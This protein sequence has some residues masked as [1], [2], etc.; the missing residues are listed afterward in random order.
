MTADLCNFCIKKNTIFPSVEALELRLNIP[1][2]YFI[3]YDYFFKSSAGDARWKKACLDQPEMRRE[4]RLASRQ[5]EAF[6]MLVLKNNYFAW[7]LSA[8]E[9]MP[10]L[11]TDYDSE[12]AR[13]DRKSCVEAYLG[14]IEID[15]EAP[16]NDDNECVSYLVSEKEEPAR[17]T[18]IKKRTDTEL[19]KVAREAKSNALYKKLKAELS[20]NPERSP[21][22]PSDMSEED[23]DRQEQKKRRK[24]MKSFREYTMKNKEEEGFKGWSKRAADDMTALVKKLKEQESDC[25]KFSAAY[26]E[27]VLSRTTRKRKASEAPLLN[28]DYSELWELDE[29]EIVAI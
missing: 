8:K 19:K 28:V 10:S 18:L 27:V 2:V 6:A 12:M 5:S 22:R 20:S 4:T 17:Y 15:L 1:G 25:C 16:G 21:T 11:V 29:D 23:F 9:S 3:F 7:L 24:V 26:R 14:G 13:K